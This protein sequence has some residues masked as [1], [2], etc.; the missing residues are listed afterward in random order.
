MKVLFLQ[1]SDLHINS[2]NDIKKF[3]VDK[4]IDA[5]NHFPEVEQL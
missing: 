3:H 4:I 2:K 1:L 5:L